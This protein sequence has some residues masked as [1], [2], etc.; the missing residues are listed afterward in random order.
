MS[1]NLQNDTRNIQQNEQINIANQC[2]R[3]PKKFWNFVDSKFKNKN[4]VGNL[5]F[6]NS[7][8]TEE[9]TSNDSQKAEILNAYFSSVFVK[10]DNIDFD[11]LKI[12]E[13]HPYGKPYH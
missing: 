9:V 13:Y 8:D 6:R 4:K 12:F 7:N 2:K 10:E 5:N 1:N 3:N 11:H